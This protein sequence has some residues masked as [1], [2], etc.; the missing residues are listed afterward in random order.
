MTRIY[1][2]KFEYTHPPA[3]GQRGNVLFLILIAVALFAALSYAVTQS[4]RSGGGD[5]SK[6]TVALAVSQLVQFAGQ[7]ENAITRVKVMNGC[8]DT[9]LNFFSP[10]HG[11]ANPSAPA[12]GL[13]DIFSDR[14][15]QVV[16]QRLPASLYDP[17]NANGTSYAGIAGFPGFGADNRVRYHGTDGNGAAS[18]DLLF[19][20]F[21][22]T[23]AAC[24]EINR[25]L[26]LTLSTAAIYISVNFTGIYTDNYLAVTPGETGMGCGYWNFGPGG[27][28]YVFYKILLAR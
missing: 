15:G 10:I 16:Y 9:Q 27:N 14:G 3:A 11:V 8:T 5:A 1:M 23:Q 20:A 13:C 22:L 7:V 17:A 4:T 28:T 2:H 19:F 26:G 24:A 6:E 25:R 12:S 18:V 21:P